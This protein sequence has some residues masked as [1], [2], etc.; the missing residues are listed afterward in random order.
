MEGRSECIYRE[1]RMER[2]EETMR[3]EMRIESVQYKLARQNDCK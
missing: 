2:L 3:L 1:A